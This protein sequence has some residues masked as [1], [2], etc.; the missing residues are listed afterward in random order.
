MD[1]Y[2]TKG[3]STKLK[4]YCL[5]LYEVARTSL[6]PVSDKAKC[7]ESEAVDS[8]GNIVCNYK[9]LFCLAMLFFYQFV[10]SMFVLNFHIQQYKFVMTVR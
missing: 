2:L 1:I 10:Y 7:I 9:F 3:N 6:R 5:C 4:R 8:L